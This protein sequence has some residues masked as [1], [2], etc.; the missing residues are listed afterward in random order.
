[1]G[2]DLTTNQ[3]IAA[4]RATRSYVFNVAIKADSEPT[5]VLDPV[6]YV[7]N[8]PAMTASVPRATSHSPNPGSH[9]LVGDEFGGRWKRTNVGSGDLAVRD[10]AW[11]Q[12]QGVKAMLYGANGMELIFRPPLVRPIP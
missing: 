4:A 8:E 5:P 1:L 2:S 11:D 12:E 7:L 10:V 9:S 6:E 3:M